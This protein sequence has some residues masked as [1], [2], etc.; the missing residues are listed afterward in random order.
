MILKLFLRAKEVRVRCSD[1][2]KDV[3]LVR[4][5]MLFIVLRVFSLK[6]VLP[7]AVDSISTVH[8]SPGL[9]SPTPELLRPKP[10]P[11]PFLEFQTGEE[12]MRESGEMC[13]KSLFR[14]CH[15]AHHCGAAPVTW[16]RPC[17]L[18]PASPAA[19]EGYS[20]RPNAVFSAPLPRAGISA[21]NMGSPLQW[22]PFHAN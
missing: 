11:S 2:S 22:L 3:T 19:G 15:V 13:R 14:A 10:C 7:I 17:W 5:T 8:S 21:V 16:L 12:S 1:G 4:M 9:Q 18:L 20:G 6:D